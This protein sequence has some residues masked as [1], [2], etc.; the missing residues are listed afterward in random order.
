MEAVAPEMSV[1]FYSQMAFFILYKPHVLQNGVT[2]MIFNVF[3]LFRFC[4]WAFCF[5]SRNLLFKKM[6]LRGSPYIENR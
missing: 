2:A 6:K 3:V 5:I 4:V 1:T